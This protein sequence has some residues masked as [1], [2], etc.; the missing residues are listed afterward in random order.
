M[1]H[2]YQHEKD[3]APIYSGLHLS[4]RWRSERPEPPVAP[5]LRK[6]ILRPINTNPAQKDGAFGCKI[7]LESPSYAGL[8]WRPKKGGSSNAQDAI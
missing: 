5:R 7:Y 4:P 3:S 6:S 1:K 2:F 8:L